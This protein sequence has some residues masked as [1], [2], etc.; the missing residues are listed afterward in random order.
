MHYMT[1]S[2]WIQFLIFL[3]ALA[4]ITKPMG[5]YLLRSLDPDKEGGLGA[6]KVLGARRAAGLRGGAGQSQEAA[7]LEAVLP[8]DAHAG[9]GDYAVSVMA[10]IACRTSCH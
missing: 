1:L 6:G 8:R 10:C 7:E 5:V 2:G 4:A 9:H 3:V